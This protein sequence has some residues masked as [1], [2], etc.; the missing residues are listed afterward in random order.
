MFWDWEELSKSFSDEI[1]VFRVVLDTTGNDETLSWGDVFHDELLEHSSINVINVFA[2]SKSWHT[3]S[4]VA[5][6]GSQQ[7][8]LLGGEWIESG[9]MVEKI[10][11]FSVFG[12]G[13]IG[14]HN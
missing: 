7:K 3:K 9:Q 2:C 1:K 14:S 12:S 13:N 5:I 10:V 6:G 8:F 11:R 4:V